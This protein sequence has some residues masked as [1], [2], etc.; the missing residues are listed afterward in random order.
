MTIRQA[1]VLQCGLVLH[2]SLPDG[3]LVWIKAAMQRG[4]EAY[5]GVVWKWREGKHRC[6]WS[7]E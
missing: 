5:K 1:S 3:R 7:H 6:I 4:R 2:V